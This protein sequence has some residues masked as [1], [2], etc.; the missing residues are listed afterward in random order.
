M[1]VSFN[2]LQFANAGRVLRSVISCV[3]GLKDLRENFMETYL[4]KYGMF[5]LCD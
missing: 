1:L 5:A 4:G 2:M 3:N